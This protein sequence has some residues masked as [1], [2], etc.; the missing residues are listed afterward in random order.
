MTKNI[1]INIPKNWYKTEGDYS[2]LNEITLAQILEAQNGATATIH[3]DFIIQAVE[4]NSAEG[5]LIL[6]FKQ[7]GNTKNLD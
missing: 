4:I 7:Y 5:D 1:I 3:N 6:T 2:L